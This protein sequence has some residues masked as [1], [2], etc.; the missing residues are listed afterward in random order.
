M[1]G[2]KLLGGWVGVERVN[3]KD[4][5]NWIDLVSGTPREKKRMKRMK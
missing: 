5:D 2:D 1:T 3:A 4:T